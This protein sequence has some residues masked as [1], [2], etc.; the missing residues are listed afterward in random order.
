M[1]R[2][3]LRTNG[4]DTGVT[5]QEIVDLAVS[6]IG[7]AW[8][9]D[10][11]TDFVWGISNLAGA[12]FFDLQDKTIAD[13]PTR[14]QDA[15][16]VV[17]HSAGIKS[18]TD[19]IAGDG[20]S[21]VFA[22]SSA[23]AMRAAL[24]PGDVVRVYK[25]GNP[26]EDSVDTAGGYAAHSFIVVSVN[27]DD[28]QVVDNW[29]TTGI[30]QHSLDDIIA[31][32]APAGQFEAAFV[33]RLDEGFAAENFGTALAGN[34]F[35]DFFGLS[36]PNATDPVAQIDLGSLDG[37][38]GFRLDGIDANDFSGWSVSGAGDV[39]GD[40]FDDVIVGAIGADPG[41][42]V[43]AGESYVVFGSGAGFPASL[44]LASLDGSDGFRLSG[45]DAGDWSGW[46]VSG[47]GD[48]NGDGFDDVIVGADLGAA[49]ESYVV[50]GSG[51]GFPASLDLASLDGSDGFRLSGTDAGDR[52]VW[53]VSGA[54]DVNGDGFDDVIVD[55]DESYVV[56]GS[57]AGFPA[58]LDLAALDGSNGFRLDG[59]DVFDGGGY[60][61]S[62]AGDVNGDGF[63]DVI[64]DRSFEDPRRE[65]FGE[66]YV[67]FG[68]GAG[69]PASLDRAGRHR[70]VPA[71]RIDAGD[72]TAFPSPAPGTSMAT[73]STM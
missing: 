5:A 60:S 11:C 58:S 22:G 35:G 19:D 8:T 62:G 55:G 42:R 71:G 2:D 21:A 51:A 43:S 14:P 48:V 40:G 1:A 56:F 63:D 9:I 13:D 73:A 4:I 16:Y 64:V 32:F 38:N 15:L 26:G 69:F 30:I 31:A 44:D 36:D 12:P 57:G 18:S 61:V 29:N 68:S 47:A 45:I 23:S 20:W 50:F 67:V 37:G 28:V 39:N 52:S 7:I 33:S 59:L 25:A 46:S 65:T 70:R 27:G 3:A 54:G 34:G 10:G 41:G 17:P 72:D 53:S 24:Q 6:N 66:S 49:G